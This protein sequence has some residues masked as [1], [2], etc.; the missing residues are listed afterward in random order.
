MKS[1]ILNALTGQ[2]FDL[3]DEPYIPGLLHFRVVVPHPRHPLHHHHHL[4]HCCFEVIY[5]LD[6][7]EKITHHLIPLLLYNYE[8][9]NMQ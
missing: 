3:V 8:E 1:F 5:L 4:V 7:I 2:Q 9:Q 6:Y